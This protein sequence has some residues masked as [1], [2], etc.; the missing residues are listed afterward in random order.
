MR[1]RGVLALLAMV[2]AQASCDPCSGIASCDRGAYLAIDGQIVDPAFGGGIDGVPVSVV[3]TGGVA[4]NADS[5]AVTTSDG[6]H[7]RVELAPH[8]A[9]AVTVAVVV[10]VPGHAPYRVPLTVQTRPHGGDATLLD[11]W[12]PEPYFAYAGELFLKGTADQRVNDAAVEFRRTGGVALR[13]DGLAGG[14]YRTR[15]DVAGRFSMFPTDGGPF[16]VTFGDVVGE[17]RVDLG[18]LGITVIPN[19]VLSPT[20]VFH[21]QRDIYRV[22][23]GPGT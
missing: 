9:G 18:P 21:R 7:W 10:A 12:I 16:P 23:V 13:G 22:A 17:L 2:T 20:P 14:V 8:D 3:R 15:T 1:V 6:G 11:P 4:V 19:V 5:V